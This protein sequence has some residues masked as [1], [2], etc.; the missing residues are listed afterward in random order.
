MTIT[1]LIVLCT[2][3]VIFVEILHMIH[4]DM[5]MSLRLEE[6]QKQKFPTQLSPPQAL[7]VPNVEA[8]FTP[9]QIMSP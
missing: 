5:M 3:A 4:L 7:N 9:P 1:L 8:K 2:H 6:D